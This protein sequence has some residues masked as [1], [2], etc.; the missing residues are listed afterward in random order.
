MLCNG[1]STA[2]VNFSGTP[3]GV[4]FNWA[5]NNTSIG[6]AASGTGNITNVLV[7]ASNTTNSVVTYTI[8]PH[9]LT[10]SNN[11]CNGTPFTFI[12][13]VNPK[14]AIIITNNATTIC[15][16]NA[17][18]IQFSSSIPGSIYYWTS[19][20]VSGS[21][22]GATTNLVGSS[23]TTIADILTNTG[24]TTATIRYK[25]TTLAPTGCGAT[26]ST[27]VLVYALP[28]TANAGLDQALCNVPNTILVGNSPASGAGRL[29]GRE[30][31]WPWSASSLAA[32][33]CIF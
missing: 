30:R 18:N 21:A 13:T 5:N 4:V 32:R 26:D 33:S 7:N 10:P 15:T 14:P 3:T 17:T 23:A 6:L 25:I 19:S 1:I 8:T 12:A 27:D 20:N 29:P 31:I 28:T 2:A 24:L 9:S 11:T 16:G 22:N